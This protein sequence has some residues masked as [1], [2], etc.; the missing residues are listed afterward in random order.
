MGETTDACQSIKGKR[1]R[2][3][4]KAAK[5]LPIH[6]KRKREE[7][8]AAKKLSNRKEKKVAKKLSKN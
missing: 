6:N 8:K 1:K 4:K 2:E 3:E 5:K 7:R